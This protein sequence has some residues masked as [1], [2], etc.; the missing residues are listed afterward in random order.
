MNTIV[1]FFNIYE[2]FSFFWKSKVA[3][4]YIVKDIEVQNTDRQLKNPSPKEYSTI[5]VILKI[6]IFY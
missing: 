5:I 1:L 3:I 6:L 4:H 2:I